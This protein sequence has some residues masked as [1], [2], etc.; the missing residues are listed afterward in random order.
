MC[1]FEC[2]CAGGFRTAVEVLNDV[3]LVEADGTDGVCSSSYVSRINSL[4]AF[5]SLARTFFRLLRPVVDG[6]GTSTG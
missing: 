4:N 6:G 1:V 3:F 2:V 5:G